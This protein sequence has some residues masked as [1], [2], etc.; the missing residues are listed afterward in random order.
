[1]NYLQEKRA[2]DIDLHHVARKSWITGQG[3]GKTR[4]LDD[5]RVTAS[6]GVSLVDSQN[7]M[8]Y[9]VR[10]FLPTLC[11]KDLGRGCPQPI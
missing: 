3:F 2:L 8:T 5:H 1:V 7:W 4:G 11:S 6:F 10:G 9:I